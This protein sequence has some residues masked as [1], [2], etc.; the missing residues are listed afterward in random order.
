[1]K[2]MES[3]IVITFAIMFVVGVCL[4]GL[5]SVISMQ[6]NFFTFAVIAK[7]LIDALMYLIYVW[8]NSRRH[9]VLAYIGFFGLGFVIL[10]ISFSS[11]G[12]AG[13]FSNWNWYNTVM[14]VEYSVAFLIAIY[15]GEKLLEE[16][17]EKDN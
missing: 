1:M 4:S 14:C 2:R 5:Y 7:G 12:V 17:K 8:M 11:E 13:T 16:D 10:F 15:Q 6:S 9:K 3:R